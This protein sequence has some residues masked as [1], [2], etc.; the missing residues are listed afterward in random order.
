LSYILDIQIAVPEFKHSQENVMNFYCNSTDDE[1]IKRK[2]KVISTKAKINHR[3]SIVNDFSSEPKDYTFFPKNRFI[4]P[5]V[6]ISERMQLFKQHAC[7]LSIKAVKKIKNFDQLKNSIT[8]IITVTC[9]GLSA[10][11]LDIEI[12]RELQLNNNIQRNSINFMGCN[13]AILALKNA[14][15]IC[16]STAD[17]NVLIVCT[18]LS[19]LHFQKNYEDDYITSTALFGDGCAAMIIS[20]IKP[21][22]PFYAPIKIVSFHSTLL[23]AGANEMAWHISDKGFIINLTSYVSQ[24]INGRIKE[25]LNSINI[26][27]NKI[28]YWAIHPGGKKILD[29]FREALNLSENKLK[30]SYDVL[31]NYGNMSSPTVL[32][33]L[34]QIIETNTSEKNGETIFTAAF[35]PGLSIE[36]MLLEYV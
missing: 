36:T 17:A 26:N 20:S 23:H 5:E 31:K 10:P 8:H 34:K 19:T 6:G 4:E 29:D 7:K 32:F 3:Y 21:Q 33:V 25:M 14:D 35:G 9:T 12:A 24:L 30:N 1:S 15:A 27:T 2:I 13:A 22:K 11:G 18:E 28:D 16:K